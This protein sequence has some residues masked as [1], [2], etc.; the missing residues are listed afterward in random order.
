MN[1]TETDLSLSS[2]SLWHSFSLGF[3][4][5]FYRVQEKLERWIK[6]FSHADELS[7]FSDLSILFLTTQ[8]KFLDH[9]T[10][11]HL[12]RMTLSIFSMKKK[13]ARST[14]FFPHQR[15]LEISWIPSIL[16]FPFTSKH[17]LGC[18]I[19]FNVMDRYELFDEENIL[20]ALQKFLPDLRLVKDST[21]C[22][23]LQ[24]RNLK[25]FYL[26][27]EKIDGKSFSLAEQIL[28]KN[29][30]QERIKS[31]IQKLS[32]TIYMNHNEE[33]IYKNIL[34]L[35]QEIQS[36]QDLPQAYISLDRQTGKE[37]V[38]LVSL[39]Y[40]SKPEQL[41]FDKC[42]TGG[43]CVSHRT[44]TVKQLRNHPVEA[45]ILYIHIPRVASLLRSD[46][47]L[48]FYT[49]RQKVAGLIREAVGEFRDYN[50]GIIINQQELLHSFKEEFSETSLQDPELIESFFYAITP[51]ENQVILPLESL[52]TLFNYFLEAR[53]EKLTE[54][55]SYS[56]KT[57]R[58]PRQIFVVVQGIHH[59]IKDIISAI[60]RDY[61]FKKQEIAYAFVETEEG[62]FFTCLL[63]ASSRKAE[64][65][66]IALHENLR[67]GHKE[68]NDRRIL[69]V[70]MNYS[71]VSL[72]PRTG[73][74]IPSTHIVKLLFEGLTRFN[75]EGKIENAIAESIDVSSDYKNYTFK[76]RPSFWNDGSPLTAHDFDYAWKK[77]LSPRFKTPFAYLLYPIRNAEAAK[78]GK[79][80]VDQIGIHVQD[81][82][83]LHI[84]LVHPTP[85]FL[86]LT[87]HT[88]Y[89]PIHRLIDRQ[90]PEWPYQVE[91][92]FP[93]NGPFQLKVNQTN[94]GIQLAKNPYYY[95]SEAVMLDQVVLTYMS[96]HRAVKAFERN[97]VDW[98]GNPFG[99]WDPSYNVDQK[100]LDQGGQLAI[101]QDL[102]RV[103]WCSFN[104]ANFP[105]NHK[106][107]R[108]AFAYAIDR[109]KLLKNTLIPID[110]AYAILLPHQRGNQQPLYPKQ[111]VERA[112][113]LLNE[114]L[115]EIGLSK[116]NLLFTLLCNEVGFQKLAA[117]NLKGQLEEHLGV[118]CNLK[119]LPWSEQ[120]KLMVAGRFDIG[121]VN[122]TPMIHDPIYTLGPFKSTMPTINFSQWEHPEFRRTIEIS[123][124]EVDLEKRHAHLL[125]AEQMLSKE[126]P[127]VPLFYL[128]SKALVRKNL[129]FKIASLYLPGDFRKVL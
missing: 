15:N 90:H 63:Q 109:S 78:E 67:Q 105:F 35:S 87:A 104:T 114:G 20:L 107:L 31:T 4:P 7:V 51:I 122:W 82:L 74:D 18:L 21:Y 43:T 88:L 41:S 119:T 3:H 79:V 65:F 42:L 72:D 100:T 117:T 59:S 91:K 13:L 48:N 73:G 99:L 111:D 37:I 29:K 61:G 6:R 84:E 97:E 46:G 60:V 80:S 106:K 52:S 93:C 86:H 115:Q 69:R 45:H 126:M 124:Q 64:P 54:G 24:H 92:N 125:N 26:E 11:S 12:F 112:R 30:L 40:V 47:S 14:T 118:K 5:A 22:H 89:S 28:L 62:L 55:V 71:G 56:F 94:Q 27:I 1:L 50:G 68:M 120:F 102:H 77:I 19:G 10:S 70:G 39:V 110:P 8:K 129:D 32:P 66:L 2:D 95:H 49:A 101:S 81:P 128:A 58:K 75:Q 34:L 96:P 53:K 116:E 44:V 23:T 16:Q 25:L 85:Y 98:V 108:L 123:E 17:V 9:R 36:I 113:Q 38:F 76:L 33:E 83:T 57:H 121:L 127:V 103:C